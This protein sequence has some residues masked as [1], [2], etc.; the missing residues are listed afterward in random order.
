MKVC[1]NLPP[2]L[3]VITELSHLPVF[4]DVSCSSNESQPAQGLAEASVGMW[5]PLWRWGGS[6]LGRRL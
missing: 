2:V 1:V 6:L 3:I 4:P 5:K